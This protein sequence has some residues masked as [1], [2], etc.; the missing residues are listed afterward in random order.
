MLSSQADAEE[1]TTKTVSKRHMTKM[2]PIQT[3]GRQPRALSVWV[4]HRTNVDI[5]GV[6]NISHLVC[7]LD[8]TGIR[9]Y[10]YSTTS[11]PLVRS[12]RAFSFREYA[13]DREPN[14]FICD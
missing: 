11:N 4:R 12:E 9:L 8:W 2:F 14:C 6:E 5:N 3:E 10:L 7:Y 13:V 1:I